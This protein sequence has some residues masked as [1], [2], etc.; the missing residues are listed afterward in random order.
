MKKALALALSLLMILVLLAG[1]EGLFG[2]K[3]DQPVTVINAYSFN[4][5]FQQVLELYCEHK[6]LP[7]DYINFTEIGNAND[8]YTQALDEVIMSGDVDIFAL[9]ASY[10]KKYTDNTDIADINANLGIDV[11]AEAKAAGIAP[12]TLEVGTGTDGVVRGL[13]FQ[14]TGSVLIYRADI[15]DRVWGDD[16]SEFISG[17]IKDWDSFFMAAEDLKKE[18]VAIVSGQMDIFNLVNGSRKQPWVVDG[19]LNMENNIMDFFDMAKKLVDE[20]YSNQT[21]M[22]SDPS[23]F[24]DMAG[25]GEKPVFAFYGPAWLLNTQIGPNS[26]ELDSETG[27]EN[28]SFG[29]WRLAKSHVPFFWGGTWIMAAKSNS[30]NKNDAIADIMRWICLNTTDEGFQYKWANNPGGK[31]LDNNGKPRLGD[32]VPSSVVMNKSEAYWPI[33]GNTKDEKTQNAFE[34]FVPASANID[35]STL[36]AYDG[37]INELF[38]E[39][40]TQYSLDKKDLDTAVKDFKK[41]VKEAFADVEVD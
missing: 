24:T 8:A 3:E 35:G 23:W 20:G 14:T 39:Q 28:G 30:Q 37:R 22:W 2:P 1:C 12:Y 21:T 33:L 41:G 7:K 10:V 9:D 6:G 13:S 26:S 38:L 36:S 27:E 11:A 19:K 15:A 5:E 16:S 17:M 31:I 25:F 18:G 32:T 4:N 29:D 40:V 34:I